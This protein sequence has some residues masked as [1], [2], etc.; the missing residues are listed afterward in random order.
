MGN[1]GFL[2]APTEF[3]VDW[4][5]WHQEFDDFLEAGAQAVLSVHRAE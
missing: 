3:Q 1:D 5:E 2:K 4:A